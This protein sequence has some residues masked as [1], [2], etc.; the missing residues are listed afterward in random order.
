MKNI[1][2]KFYHLFYSLVSLLALSS[3]E[4]VINVD[5]PQGETQLV[6]DAWV[7]NQTGEQSIKLT[8]S[9]SYFDNTPSP[10]ALGATVQVTDNEGNAYNFLDADNDGK[11]VWTPADAN[12]LGKIG[13]TYTLQI[14]F[15]G[16]TYSAVSAINPVPV[17]DSIVYELRDE[18]LGNP[19]GYYAEFYARDF[20]GKGNCYWIRGFKN[21]RYLNRVANLT[22]AYDAGFS[23]GGNTDGINFIRPI[24]EGINE[25]IPD[26]DNATSFTTPPYKVGDKVKVELYSITE[27]AFNFFGE[28]RTQLQNSGLFAIPLANVS[29]NL[30]NQNPNSR[31][32]ALG[33][34]GA[35]AVSILEGTIEDKEKGTIKPVL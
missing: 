25:F 33:F 23:A 27:P 12:P 2:Y 16:E 14:T 24:R 21:E 8:R 13:N 29:T 1:Q 30:V 7:T 11:Y 32:R 18:E 20:A 31:A 19:K 35:S 15:E 6:V 17:V 4:D 34:F 3:C 10:A 9:T 5:L 26:A 22:T 28:V